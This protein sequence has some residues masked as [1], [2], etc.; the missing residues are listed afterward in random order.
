M[1]EFDLADGEFVCVCLATMRCNT[2]TRSLKKGKRNNNNNNFLFKEKN[3]NNKFYPWKMIFFSS[4]QL[5]FI[6]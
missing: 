4:P 1:D 5:Y 2:R 3:L 6:F